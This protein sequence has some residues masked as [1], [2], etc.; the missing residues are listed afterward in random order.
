MVEKGQSLGQ[1]LRKSRKN[2]FHK[3]LVIWLIVGPVV[4]LSVGLIFGLYAGLTLGLVLGVFFAL[5][6]GLVDGGGGEALKFDILRFYLWRRGVIPW[7]Y[8]HFLRETADLLLLEQDGGAVEFRHL[9]LRN[10]FAE[11]TPERINNLTSRIESRSS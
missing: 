8:F 6:S 11:L 1:R 4:G 10:Y 9:L 2:G 7:H 3:G 5:Y